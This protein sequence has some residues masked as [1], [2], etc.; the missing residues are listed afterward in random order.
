MRLGSAGIPSSVEFLGEFRHGGV[1]GDGLVDWPV[2]GSASFDDVEPYLL[3]AVVLELQD[4]GG[5]VREVNNAP[6]DDGSAIVD[7]DHDGPSV[8][9]VGDSHIASQRQR[10]MSGSQVVHVEVLTA[11]GLL[12]VGIL[13]IP[14][15]CSKLI[16][17][18]FAGLAADFRL[19]SNCPGLG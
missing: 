7:F 4:F 10:W 5:T 11:G 18:M 14:R 15:G 12:T 3:Q 17:L 1:G 9:Q 13:A 8:A 6:L 19:G 2:L 16:R